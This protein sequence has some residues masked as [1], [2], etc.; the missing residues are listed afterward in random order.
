MDSATR[1]NAALTILGCAALAAIAAVDLFPLGYMIALSSRGGLG[2]HGAGEPVWLGPWI[3][4]FRSAPLFGRWFVNSAAVTALTVSFHLIA[5]AMAAYVLAKGKFRGRNFAFVLVIL[6]MMIPRQ[7]TLIPLFLRMG[8]LG[9]ADTFWGLLLPGLGDVVGIFLIRQFLLTVPDS[10][11][12][13]ARIDGAG[14]WGTFFY[15]VMP[16]ARPALAV[17]AVL[18]TLHYW[19][20]FFWPLVITTSE[21]NFTIQVGLAYLVRS[22]D[23]GPDIPLM[24]AGACAAAIPPLVVFLLL[25]GAFFEGLRAGAVK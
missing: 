13:A 18:A 7:V 21:P 10:L 19:S 20:D 4:L 2:E 15:I 8:R 3:R 25:R 14:Q 11:L 5:D 17:L 24:A 23:F 22:E 16:L 1:K 6:A 12:E 9:L